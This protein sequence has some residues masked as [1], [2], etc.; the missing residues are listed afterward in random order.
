MSETLF[1]APRNNKDANSK[2]AD[3]P[4]RRAMVF[5]QPVL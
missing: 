5:R 3:N 4:P 2:D 1:F